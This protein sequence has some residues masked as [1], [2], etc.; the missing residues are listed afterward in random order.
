MLDQ[1]LAEVEAGHPVLV[2]VDAFFLPDTQG[3]SYRT[4]HT[5]TTIAVVALDTDARTLTYFHNQSLHQ[6]DGEDWDGVFL[7]AVLAPYLEVAKPV[8][9]GLGG[10]DLAVAA[11]E[12]LAR[13]VGRAP[14]D[15]PFVRWGRRFDQEIQRLH[16]A[17][18][19]LYHGWSFATFRQFGAAFSLA[20]SHLD[21]LAAQGIG[22]D[23]SA[24]AADAFRTISSTGKALQF[25]CARAA[26]AGKPIDA[27][28]ISRR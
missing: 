14:V 13:H 4:E 6:L 3:S 16:E 22:S 7:P 8:A 5:K 26:F 20:A 24:A 27:T 25:R 1:T 9:P 18:G 11:H 28:R 23:R 15:N 21:W 10:R 19:S 17:G 2:E 12:R